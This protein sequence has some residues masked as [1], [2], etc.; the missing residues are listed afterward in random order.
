MREKT[1]QGNSNFR[2][3]WV[4]GGL[5]FL[6]TAINY[7]DRQTFPILI[8]E[9]SKEIPIDNLTFAR[10]N[11]AFLFT[12]A[13]MYAG[14]GWLVDRLG[15]RWGYALVAGF[16]S[17]SCMLHSL[18]NSV[19]SLGA[20]RLMLGAGEGGGF[21]ASAKVVSEWFTKKDR[22][23]AM[24]LFNTGSAV[25]AT[26]A[27]PLIAIIAGC[28]SWR[29]AFVLFGCIGL[30]WVALWLLLYRPAESAA[31]RAVKEKSTPWITLLKKKQVWTLITVKFLTD[32]PWFFLI[33]WLPKYLNDAR[34]FNLKEIGSVAWIP[35]ACAGIGSL[36]GGWISSRL[37]GK[38]GL[39]RARKTSLLISGIFFPLA[40]AI[41]SL[42]VAGAILVMCVLFLAHQFWSVN[43]QT[44]PADIFPS[45]QVGS[46]AGIIGC[47]GS[48]GAVCFG[49]LVGHLLKASGGN[50]EWPFVMA[51]LLHPVS[52][53]ILMV[54]LKK[55]EPDSHQSICL[56]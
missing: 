29:A 25:G 14:G 6:I 34:G 31:P 33:F 35:Y 37:V 10:L 39:D 1:D 52:I 43:M 56:V 55:I 45:A 47:A 46:V 41:T 28:W 18:A 2:R 22:A 24:G 40:W 54:F 7:L 13:L 42:P 20:F 15:S 49:E 48:L 17:L 11:S 50:Y 4:I 9:I 19:F 16:W 44:L 23:M 32:G 27:P 30:V 53:V 26:L 38:L 51:G 8:K 5:L 21:P 36:A 12:Y 3:W